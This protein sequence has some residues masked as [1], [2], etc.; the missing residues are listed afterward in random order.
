MGLYKTLNNQLKKNK[1]QWGWWDILMIVLLSIML[2]VFTSLIQHFR[3]HGFSTAIGLDGL[4]PFVPVFII[5]YLFHFPF[6]ILSIYMLRNAPEERKGLLTSLFL[7][8]LIS[9]IIYIIWQTEMVRPDIIVTDIFTLLTSFVYSFDSMVNLLPSLHVVHIACCL[10][11][12]RNKGY[13]WRIVGFLIIISTV[14]VKQHYIL[15]IF[16]GIALAIITSIISV[17]FVKKYILH[18]KH[19]KSS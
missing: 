11:F 18:K 2:F 15:D 8:T 1:G 12:I 10:F 9:Q 19:K 3:S 13:W 6:I 7:A 16:T 5:P 17:F 14:F 4:I